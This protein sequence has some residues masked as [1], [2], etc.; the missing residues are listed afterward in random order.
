MNIV[1]GGGVQV[2]VSVSV[3]VQVSVQVEASVSVAQVEVQISVPAAICAQ[4]YGGLRVYDHLQLGVMALR[5]S[6]W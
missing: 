6:C 2:S 3:V 1:S 4:T 5:L